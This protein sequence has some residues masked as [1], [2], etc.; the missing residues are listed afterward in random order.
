VLPKHHE[1]P[2]LS[3]VLG[4]ASDGADYWANTLLN[5]PQGPPAPDEVGRGPTYFRWQVRLTDSIAMDDP[6]QA[7]PGAAL[8]AAAKRLIETRSAEIDRLVERLL[9]FDPLPYDPPA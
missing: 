5:R 9:R 7:K 1:A 8:P 2:I 6:D 4:G 3:T